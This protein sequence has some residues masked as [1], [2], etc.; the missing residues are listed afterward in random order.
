MLRSTSR[1]TL[2]I[3]G[4]RVQRLKDIS[5]NDARAEGIDEWKSVEQT[6]NPV[7]RFG[8]LWTSIN[9]RDSWEANPW[10][11]A[12]AFKVHKCNVDAVPQ[13]GRH[14]QP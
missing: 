7:I 8:E 14:K 5:E 9:G 2:E 12:L 13:P 4:V 1:L 3:T 6:F 11:W 10:V